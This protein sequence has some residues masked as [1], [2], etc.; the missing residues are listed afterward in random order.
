MEEVSIFK[1]IA[2]MADVVE[3]VEENTKGLCKEMKMSLLCTISDVLF[4][5]ESVETFEK[6]LPLIKEVNEEIGT[7][8]G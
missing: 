7:Y 5:A 4:G 2:T 3:F 8:N 6:C 1:Q